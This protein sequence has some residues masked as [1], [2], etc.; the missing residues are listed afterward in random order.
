MAT[1]KLRSVSC[2]GFLGINFTSIEWFYEIWATI[3]RLARILQMMQA[4]NP[5]IHGFCR[6]RLGRGGVVFIIFT[7]NFDDLEFSSQKVLKR[8]THTYRSSIFLQRVGYW[9]KT[10]WAR[11]KKD[12]VKETCKNQDGGC[13]WICRQHSGS[14][15]LLSG[16]FPRRSKFGLFF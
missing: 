5:G 4:Q 2:R 10:N 3:R 1:S 13:L 9:P 11:L 12:W 6:G 8:S 14:K 7:D 16:Y 15:F